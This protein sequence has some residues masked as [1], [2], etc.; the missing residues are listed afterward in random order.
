MKETY[1]VPEVEIFRFARA[2]IIEVS[3]EEEKPA[4]EGR[5]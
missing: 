1:E 5:K 4:E 3:K 2:D